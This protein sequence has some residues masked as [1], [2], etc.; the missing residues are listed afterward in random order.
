[1][2]SQPDYYDREKLYKEVWAEPVPKVAE[3]YVVSIV[4]IAKTRRIMHIPVPGTR[5]FHRAKTPE[6]N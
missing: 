6:N 4:A 1:M 2:W 3:R 5:I